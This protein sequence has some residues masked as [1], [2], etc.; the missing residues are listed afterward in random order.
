MSIPTT[1]K[2]YYGDET[3]WFIGT[4]IQVDNDPEELGRVKIRIYGIHPNDPELASPD[5]LPWASVVLPSTEAGVS[6]FGGSTGIKPSA[7][8][9]GIFLD[10]KNSQLPLVLG[11]IPKNESSLDRN[12]REKVDRNGTYQNDSNSIE[13]ANGGG[14]GV[15]KYAS[16][17][18]GQTRNKKI[19]PELMRI[20]ETA[21]TAAGVE[22]EIFSGGQDRK[23]HGYRRTGSTR[24]DDGFAADIRVKDSQNRTLKTNGYDAVMNKF[25]TE[26]GAAGAQGLGA[27]P[28]YMGGTGVH[29][30]LWGSRKGSE[31]WGEGGTGSPP[32]A[33][34]IAFREGKKRFNQSGVVTSTVVQNKAKEKSQASDEFEI[35]A[36]EAVKR[37][38]AAEGSTKTEVGETSDA[39]FEVLSTTTG[40]NPVKTG[41][42][43]AEVKTAPNI[44]KN[45]TSKNEVQAL[46][47][48]TGDT[49]AKLDEVIAQASPEG[50][51]VALNQALSVPETDVA[52]IVK[53]SSAIPEVVTKAVEEIQT[54]GI[55]SVLG[56]SAVQASAKVAAELGFPIGSNNTFGSIMSG[57]GNILPQVLA[58]AFNQ[59][60]IKD[61]TK[62]F[63]FVPEG[64]LLTDPDG[65]KVIP[66]AAMKAGG[67][68]NVSEAVSTK[69]SKKD[70]YF[71]GLKDNEWRG[72]NTRG[73]AIGGTYEFKTLSTT[74]HLEAEFRYASNQREITSLIIDWTNLGNGYDDYSVDE[75]H[76]KIS[77]MHQ[78]KY[79]I[80][81]VNGNP[82]NYGF[83]THMYIHQSGMIKRVVPPKNGINALRYP[84][85]QQIYN[86]C[87]HITL[88]SSDK[89]ARPHKQ[90]ESVDEIIKAFIR[91][92]PGAEILGANDLLPEDATKA[93]GFSVKKYIK[94]KFNKDSTYFDLPISEIASAKELADR[95]P[96]TSVVNQ[97]LFNKIPDVNNLV[98]AF[99][100]ATVDLAS[101]AQTFNN[102][103]FEVIDILRQKVEKA[104]LKNLVDAS[105]INDADVEALDLEL[106]NKLNENINNK[107]EA[108]KA[109]YR[110]DEKTKTFREWDPTRK[111]F[112]DEAG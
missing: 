95:Q 56:N 73:T 94:S 31:M 90:M 70:T 5:D 61:L 49:A 97:S 17:I 13:Y 32:N 102:D 101:I 14:E 37:R 91:V 59:P 87:I 52:N 45:L 85:R 21:A 12:G 98:N 1:Y 103:N 64:V 81:T 72:A 36:Q 80:N 48:G 58:N 77:E 3:R 86:N 9:F 88:N 2:D 69:P 51:A 33:I 75:I 15:V 62:D 112:K 89:S 39:G 18:R 27:H 4:V 84:V 55:E 40:S 42:V 93:P 50:M 53:S 24:H 105:G 110:W 22:V 65:N 10:G 30:D 6:G 23:G 104:N 92:F 25:I 41:P 43:V 109:G 34:K 20:I 99:T 57:V 78:S 107:L 44:E 35:E 66:P 16:F 83:L 7:Q 54:G 11:T 74:D 100:K 26:L 76:Q 47:G 38:V 96:S 8:V 67:I 63:A 111:L 79:G 106:N 60:G 68:S 29:V 108:M 19:Q 46:T 71:V 28:R 82:N